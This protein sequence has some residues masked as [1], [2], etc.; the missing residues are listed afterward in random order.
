M[1]RLWRSADRFTE[2][3]RDT[4]IEIALAIQQRRGREIRQLAP[5]RTP[6]VH[7]GSG[8]DRFLLTL[9]LDNRMRPR[10]G[11]MSPYRDARS[12]AY[13]AN[14]RF[15]VPLENG[16]NYSFETTSRWR[17]CTRRASTRPRPPPDFTLR[18]T[19]R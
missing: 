5:Q 8:T 17:D 9:I 10:R 19:F 2:D 1:T 15:V 13:P 18:E 11:S 14:C 4:R 7:I 16:P 3:G 12:F 6:C